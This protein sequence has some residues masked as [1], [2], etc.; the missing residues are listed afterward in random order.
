MGLPAD[1][2]EATVLAAV[3]QLLDR[4]Q[5][6][7]AGLVP[8]RNRITELEQANAGLLEAQ[9][10]LDLA[11]YT[12]RLTPEGRQKWKAAL[13]AD[14]ARTFELLSALPPEPEGSV[15]IRT[16][17]GRAPMHH[18]A[19]AKHPAGLGTEQA[20][21][22]AADAQR[23]AVQEYKNRAHCTWLEAWNA[24]RSE[25]PELFRENREV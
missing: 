5:A 25:R 22:D 18:Q 2:T 14:R 21:T 23:R 9:V 19:A 17:D 6:A 15:A 24:L 1:A 13:L 10:E 20:L 8:L 12:N 16:G 4:A 3:N 7:Q 11:P